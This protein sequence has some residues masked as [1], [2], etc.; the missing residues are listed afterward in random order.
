[1]H[2]LR[3]RFVK[4]TRLTSILIKKLRGT[5]K[6]LNFKW[7]FLVIAKLMVN[8]IALNTSI[9]GKQMIIGFIWFIS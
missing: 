5:L 7:Y 9:K 6:F 8:W 1:M 2:N 3:D 4:K